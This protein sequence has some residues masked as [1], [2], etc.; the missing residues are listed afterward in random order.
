MT[1]DL[2]K[3]SS[4][5]FIIGCVGIESRFEIVSDAWEMLGRLSYRVYAMVFYMLCR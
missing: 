1:Y 2:G 5:A 3:C 4:R